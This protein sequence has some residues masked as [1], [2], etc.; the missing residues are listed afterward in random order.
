MG[1]GSARS[2]TKAGVWKGLFW[3]SKPK[4]RETETENKQKQTKNKCI[5][6]TRGKELRKKR[7]TAME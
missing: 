2:E 7:T 1:G 6:E 3:K 4:N 5:K